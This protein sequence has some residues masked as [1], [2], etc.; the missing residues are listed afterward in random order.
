MYLPTNQGMDS[1]EAAHRTHPYIRN[2]QPEGGGGGGDGDCIAI[3]D[4]D[5]MR[6]AV[7]CVRADGRRYGSDP[8]RYTYIR[9]WYGG[10]YIQTYAATA[11]RPN[12]R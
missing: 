12:Y 5:V 4:D 7:V 3:R 2:V 10:T 8:F 1:P 6:V 11:R 9:T